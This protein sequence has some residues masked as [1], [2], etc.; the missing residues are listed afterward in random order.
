MNEYGAWWNDT[1]R[2]YRSAGRKTCH[3]AS[4]CTTYLTWTDLRSNP[5]LHGVS[6]APNLLSH[7]MA[8]VGRTHGSSWHSSVVFWTSD[9][10]S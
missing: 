8:S 1:D 6:P 5:D 3:S 9:R 7:G 2:G 10:L 4:F